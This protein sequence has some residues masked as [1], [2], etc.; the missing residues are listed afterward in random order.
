MVFGK[1]SNFLEKPSNFFAKLSNFFV[2]RCMVFVKPSNFF[3]KGAAFL[4]KPKLKSYV[5]YRVIIILCRKIGIFTKQDK[6]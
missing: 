5:F 3:K 4:K 6:K 1:P 2:K